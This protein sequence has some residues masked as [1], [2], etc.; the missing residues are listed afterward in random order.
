MEKEGTCVGCGV[1]SVGLIECNCTRR[2]FACGECLDSDARLRCGTCSVRERRE[3]PRA[4]Y[5][6]LDHLEE[7]PGAE[8]DRGGRFPVTGVVGAWGRP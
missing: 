8:R 4:A 2:I 6:C 1:E 7:D 5:P 3:R